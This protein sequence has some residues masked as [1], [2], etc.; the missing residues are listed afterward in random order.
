MITFQDYLKFLQAN[1]R[2]Y[3][4][5][6]EALANLKVSYEALTSAVY[7]LKK[8]G[9]II[10]PLQGFFVIIPPE[11]QSMGCLPAE[12]LMPMLMKHLDLDYYVCLL[13]AALYHGAS[14]QKPQLFQVMINKQLKSIVCGKVKI[15][16]I[17]KKNWDD[18]YTQNRIVKSGYLKIATPELTAMDLFLYPKRS[19]GL[20]H[21]ATVLS[22]LLEAVN[23]DELLKIISASQQKAWIQR[24]GYV[25]EKIDPIEIEK[26]DELVSAI[27]NYLVKQTISFVPLNPD[28]SKKGKN[29]NRDWMIIENTTIESDE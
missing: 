13:S 24:L 8:K 19:G 10:S 21:I 18:I 29:R 6:E 16:F 12:E 25:L 14:H 5:V 15:E 1:G 4:T 11:Y 9:E 22:E 26:R 27:K 20:N 23:I 28:F 2:P 3:F 7:R 17:Y